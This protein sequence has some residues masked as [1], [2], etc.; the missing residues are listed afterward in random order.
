MQAALMNI[1]AAVEELEEMC[2]EEPEMEKP[3]PKGRHMSLVDY[4]SS[5][6]ED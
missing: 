5:S 1:K 6:S 4:G 3:M 2:C